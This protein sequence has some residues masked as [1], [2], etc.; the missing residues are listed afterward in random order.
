M[1]AQSPAKFVNEVRQE[2]RKVTWPTRKETLISTAM[3]LT[4][5][6]FAAVFFVFVDWAIHSII[7]LILGIA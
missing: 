7:N 6:A 1:A 3:V 2:M 5:V 4:L